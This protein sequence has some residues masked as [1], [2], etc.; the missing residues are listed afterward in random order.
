MSQ[1]CQRSATERHARCQLAQLVTEQSFLR[2]SLVERARSCGKPTCRCQQGHLHRSLYLAVRHQGRRA[3]LFI[4]WA[5]EQTVRPVAP[6]GRDV[7]VVGHD[8]EPAATVH[9]AGLA[10]GS[11][12]L[13]C[14]E[15]LLQ[16]LVHALGPGSL[17]QARP[18]GDRQFGVDPV[19]G[20][21][22]APV[23]LAA[24]PQSVV[25]CGDRY[26]DWLGR[27]NASE[28]EQCGAGTVVRLFGAAA[29]N[30]GRGQSVGR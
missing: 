6:E 12:P 30:R 24:E 22:A 19:L 7:V 27:G 18:G 20:V 26:A 11:S 28:P 8:P 21:R 15:R 25:A 4:P 1:R 5:L 17:L 14:G 2:G 13:G 29:L 16:H 3:L 10:G 23:L 9:A